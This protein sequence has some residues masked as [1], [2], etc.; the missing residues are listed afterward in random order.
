ML[1]DVASASKGT[2][3]YKISRIQ[4]VFKGIVNRKMNIKRSDIQF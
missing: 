4:S 2:W 1:C 3:I